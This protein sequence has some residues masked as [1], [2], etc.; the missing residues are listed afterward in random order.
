[1]L[2]LTLAVATVL[3]TLSLAAAAANPAEFTQ[4]PGFFVNGKA[5]IV[6]NASALKARALCFDAFAV[7]H[8][9]VAHAPIYSTQRLNKAILQA[10]HG[11]ER[12]DK[13]Y[14]EGRL[15]RSERATLED[16]RGSGY[17]RGHASEAA[18]MPTPSAMAQSFSLANVIL[19]SPE[20]NRGQWAKTVEKA[21]R[22]YIMRAQGDV[23]VFTGPVFDKPAKV[24]GPSQV[25]VPRYIYKL[26]FDATTHRAWAHYLEN[27]NEAKASRPISYRE[28]VARTGIEFL[29]GVDVRD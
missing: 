7:L 18:A 4:C 26:V 12:T 25:W 19:Q 11:Q 3:S 10:A 29:P 15:P 28:L 1:M 13:F 22:Q 6:P 21:T 2:K 17:D 5:P 14:E 23:Y 24:L 27:T 20:L 16:F 9:G 8:S